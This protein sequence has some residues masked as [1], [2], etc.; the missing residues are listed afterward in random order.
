MT[1]KDKPIAKNLD[2]YIND[3]ITN[4]KYKSMSEAIEKL[5]KKILKKTQD[6]KLSDRSV[7]KWIYGETTPETHN[8]IAL[9]EILGVSID[10]L[11]KTEISKFYEA[12]TPKWYN[13]LTP[14]EKS[15]FTHIIK[16]VFNDISPSYH[17]NLCPFSFPEQLTEDNY[18]QYLLE[19]ISFKFNI[20]DNT[21]TCDSTKFLTR[22]DI[23]Q[24]S[25]CHFKN[26]MMP[27]LIKNYID[28]SNSFDTN[29]IKNVL[30]IDFLEDPDLNNWLDL[31]Y[32]IKKQNDATLN[33]KKSG[34]TLKNQVSKNNLKI[35]YTLNLGEKQEKDLFKDL[36]LNDSTILEESISRQIDNIRS[37]YFKKLEDLQI[38]QI[39]HSGFSSMNYYYLTDFNFDIREYEKQKPYYLTFYFKINLD[40]KEIQ[41]I[42]NA[43][44]SDQLTTRKEHLQ[45]LY[46]DTIENCNTTFNNI[47]KIN[48]RFSNKKQ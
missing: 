43:L 33:N 5:I 37:K 12:Q 48:K 47:N 40:L 1:N 21:A 7:R 35:N 10:D 2:K 22:D 14:D 13:E 9:S 18:Y 27:N 20:I 8:L 30:N 25:C 36:S 4:G 19:P 11:L 42:Y 29:E 41:K 16:S 6:E 46:K 24:S 38:I 32:E 28:E 39:L 31:R 3:Q 26:L 34:F 17:L 44:I 23:I 45:E 15:A